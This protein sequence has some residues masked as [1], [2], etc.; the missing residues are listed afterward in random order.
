[1]APTNSSYHNTLAPKFY[2]SSVGH[3]CFRY[4]NA[5][6]VRKLLTN[7]MLL[8]FDDICQLPFDSPCKSNC[9]T[10]FSAA[11]EKDPTKKGEA[12]AVYH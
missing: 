1:M 8:Q 6:H 7:F 9:S 4:A 2:L 3:L 12:V 5:K 11:L 10:S